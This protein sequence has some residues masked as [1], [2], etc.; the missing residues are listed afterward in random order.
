MSADEEKPSA[1]VP[2]QST[3]LTKGGAMSLAARGRDHLRD[4]EEGEKWLRK[5]IELQNAVPMTL[6]PEP[7]TTLEYIK[8]ILTGTQPDVAARNLGMTPEDH[9]RAKDA[10]KFMPGTL[11]EVEQENEQR[12][13]LLKKYEEMQ[14]EAF[15]CF[16][17][18]HVLDPINPELLYWLADSYYHG[19][20]VEPNEEKAVPLYRRAA[21]Q[22]HSEAQ[23]MLSDCYREGKGVAQDHAQAMK[24]LRKAAE[25]DNTGAQYDLALAYKYGQLGVQQDAAQA[26]IWFRKVGK[27]AGGEERI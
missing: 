24:W 15:R 7:Q 5:G 21:E 3:A 8:Q 14:Q 12:K 10:H 4:K 11:T 27:R 19:D 25:Q 17:K 6:F 13:S 16:E 22:G 26:A 9:E 2:A 23:H 1:L 18:G 20:G